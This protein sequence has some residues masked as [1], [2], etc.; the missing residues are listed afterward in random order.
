MISLNIIAFIA[1]QLTGGEA[2]V[3]PF[4]LYYVTGRFINCFVSDWTPSL[5]PVVL[6]GRDRISILQAIRYFIPAVR[7]QVAQEQPPKLAFGNIPIVRES[8]QIGGVRRPQSIYDSL[9]E[10]RICLQL[11]VERNLDVTRY[12]RYTLMILADE[13][14]DED[15]EI[16]IQLNQTLLME[17]NRPDAN[18]TFPPLLFLTAVIIEVVDFVCLRWEKTL[19]Y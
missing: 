15:A 16:K 19:Q 4:R 10:R 12:L 2:A 13:V 18:A 3:G 1:L 17:K 11:F 14:E 7:C 9:E 8:G 6:F 5:K